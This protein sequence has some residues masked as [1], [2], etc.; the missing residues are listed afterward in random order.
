M[1]RDRARRV[2]LVGWDAADWRVIHPLMDAGKMPVLERLVGEGTMANLATLHPVLS[3][4]LWTSIATGKRPFKH[5][6]L[7]F[8]EPTEDASGIRPVTS[9]SRKVK[10]LWNILGQQGLRSNV[11]GWWPSH[12][13]EPIRGA[14]VS[15]HYH[16][17]V[18]PIDQPWPMAPGTVHPPRLV[19]TLAELRFHPSE[20]LEE[21]IRA[22]IPCAHE[23]DQ[24][25]DR[26]LA[27]CLKILA[28]CASVHSAA[29][30]LLEKEPW[31]FMAVYYDAI[32]HFSHGFMKYHPPRQEH[33]PERDFELY[34]GVVE[35]GYR[36]HDQ[37]L[38]SLLELAGE[39]T[40]VLLVSDHGFHP[41]HQRP[42]CI[43]SEPAGPAAEHRDF[44]VF[45]IRGPGIKRDELIHGASLLDIAPTV[46]RLFDLPVG[47]DMDGRPL[48]ECFEDPAEV[49]TIPSWEDVE[50]DAGEHPDAAQVDPVACQESVNQLIEL[51]YIERPDPDREK[52]VANTVDELRYNLARSYIDADRH[53]EAVPILENL[54]ESELGEY[55][56]GIQLAMCYRA[57]QRIA[58]LRALVER[59]TA[60]RRQEVAEARGALR[61]LTEAIRGQGE[62]TPE[63]RKELRRL[64]SLVH[65]DTYALDYLLGFVAAAEGDHDKALSHLERAEKSQPGRPGLHIQIG[66]VYLTLKRWDEAERA[67]RRALEIDPANPHAH[68]GLSRSDLPR[69]RNRRAADS[70][71]EAVALLYHFPMAH[72]CLGVALHRMGHVDRAVQALEVAVALNP[73]FREAHLRLAR[74]YGDRLWNPAKADEHRLLA[75]QVEE[76][77]SQLVARIPDEEPVGSF[78]AP[79]QPPRGAWAAPSPSPAGDCVTVV[80]GL[81]RSGTSMMMKL[82]E[83]GGKSILSDGIRAADDDNPEGYFELEAVKNSRNDAS[84]IEEAGGSAVKVI[85]LLVPH[86]PLDRRYKVVMMHRDP[87]E[88][89]ASQRKMLERKDREGARLDEDALKRAFSK[90]L[91]RVRAYMSRRPGFEVIEMDYNALVSD[92]EPHLRRLVEFLDLPGDVADMLAV[93]DPSLYRN[94]TDPEKPP[95]LDR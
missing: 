28:E 72:F 25:K 70:A 32:D 7:G 68:L 61:E 62:A 23:V 95:G 42:T 20:L 22:F 78:A 86:L 21:D 14:M 2:L 69:R 45:A 6:V 55:R 40:T 67:F 4:M 10:A 30:W 84:W 66:E 82:I 85:H 56:F 81:P 19:E 37:M 57:L 52:A 53:G 12:P 75:A 76:T 5:G 3:P 8:T 15:N 51:G 89:L 50:G 73:N 13:A 34:R 39:D 44:G 24:E 88:V 1:S 46:L 79:G 90:Q 26:R 27:T 41:D 83:A 58:E 64:R 16:R 54:V 87:D 35:A 77:L 29:T 17:A 93:I 18:G 63:E 71:L 33:I 36:F 38:G 65:L 11:V 31:D 48:A 94:R 92:P 9:L 43:P 60:R 47:E 91:T 49:P 80:S 59:M 74:I